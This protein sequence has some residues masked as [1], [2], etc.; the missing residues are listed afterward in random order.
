ME[1]VSSSLQGL[2]QERKCHI[3]LDYDLFSAHATLETITEVDLVIP[4]IRMRSFR[5]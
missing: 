2:N 4:S 1:G 5:E 3:R